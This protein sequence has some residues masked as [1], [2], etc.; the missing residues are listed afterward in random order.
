M[1]LFLAGYALVIFAI[2]PRLPRVFALI[3]LC[4]SVVAY[5]HLSRQRERFWHNFRER[6]LQQE[7]EKK[8]REVSVRVPQGHASEQEI[9][10]AAD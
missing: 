4:V 1:F 10:S 6:K 9:P 3:L 7:I 5:L 8:Q 2:G